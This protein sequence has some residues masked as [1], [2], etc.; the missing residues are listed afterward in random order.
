M[1]P[2]SEACLTCRNMSEVEG[3]FEKL[4]RLSPGSSEALRKYTELG[5]NPL[6]RD[7]ASPMFQVRAIS[8]PTR[9]ATVDIL[10]VDG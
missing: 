4:G 1:E 9:T 10:H 2:L 6:D 3:L 5:V 8:D 7:M